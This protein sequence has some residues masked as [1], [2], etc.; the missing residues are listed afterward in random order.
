[1]GRDRAGHTVRATAFLHRLP[2]TGRTIRRLGRRLSVVADQP[3][4]AEEARPPRHRAA[5]GAGRAP[6][7]RP[8][9][10]AAVRSGE[11]AIARHAQGCQRGFGAPRP[12]HDWRSQRPALAAKP[13]GL[14][15]CAAVERALGARHGQHRKDLIRTPGR[16]RG[17]LQPA[18]ARP[19]VAR[20]SHLHAVEPAT[21]T[22]G[23]CTAR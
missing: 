1:M 5:V 6:P 13:P 21:G 11:P 9:H 22:A 10:C 8:Y 19:A 14:L 16:C 2:Q 15:H 3:E 18:Q 7:L 23:R 20:L 17:R 4:C 12:G